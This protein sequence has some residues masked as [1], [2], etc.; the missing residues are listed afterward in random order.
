MD[1]RGNKDLYE[2]AVEMC[3]EA[4]SGKG[5][6]LPSK[7]RK[8]KREKS[9]GFIL[10]HFFGK[11]VWTLKDLDDAQLLFIM[12]EADIRIQRHADRE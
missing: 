5:K 8:E 11:S 3:R 7:R 2:H 4:W 10:Q 6:T 12:K 1:P 9:L